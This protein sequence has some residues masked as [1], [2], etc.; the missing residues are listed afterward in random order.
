MFSYLIIRKEKH[1]SSN[2]YVIT[3]ASTVVPAV[4]SASIVS[5]YEIADERAGS[6]EATD[7]QGE[8][9]TANRLY[10]TMESE[11]NEQ[12]Q[13][14]PAYESILCDDKFVLNCFNT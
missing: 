14:N 11:N 6:A 7:Y 3:R 4:G 12:I 2:D 13:R 8:S 10:S 1:S 5:T 9:L